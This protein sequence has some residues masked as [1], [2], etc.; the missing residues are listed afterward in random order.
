MQSGITVLDFLFKIFYYKTSSG[1]KE[2]L[3]TQL[4]PDPHEHK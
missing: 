1:Q 4:V 3:S 2:V